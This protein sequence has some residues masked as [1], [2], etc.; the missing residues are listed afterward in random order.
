MPSITKLSKYSIF[1]LNV[2][3]VLTPIFVVLKWYCMVVQ[4]SYTGEISWLQSFFERT[5]QTPE[6][7]IY[8]DTVKWNFLSKICGIIADTIKVI[9]WV[10]GLLFLRKIFSNYKQ[11]SI[12]TTDNASYYRILG[13]LFFA[14]ALFVRSFADMLKVLAVTMTNSPGHR[15]ITVGFG[16]PNLESLFYGIVLIVISCVML[17]AAKIHDESKLTV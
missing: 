14:D 5:I 13:W 17:E 15:Y 11:G 3:V 1:L 2:L 16:T 8:F 9:P 7:V 4:F 12:F 6:G 10:I